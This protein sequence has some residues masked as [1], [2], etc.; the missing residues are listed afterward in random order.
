LRVPAFDGSQIGPPIG[1]YTYTVADDHWAWSDG[2]YELHGYESQG[3]VVT[4]ELM[5]QHKH[6]DDRARALGVLETAVSEGGPFSCYHRIIDQ[7]GR[8][9]SVLAVGRGV[10]PVHGRVEQLTGFFIDLT[11]LRRSETEA[12]VQQAL[13]GI[14]EHRAVIEQAKGV[15]MCA[16]G[17]DADEAFGILRQHSQDAN[18]KL[19]DLAHRLV[20]SVGGGATPSQAC[21]GVL[22]GFL[23]GL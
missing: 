13:L 8:I 1:Y 6:P 20:K 22:S 5:L 4:T 2:M 15:V 12:D 23:A 11:E 10:G 9:H 18:L 3:V 16:L 19:N 7:Q 17:C 21:R 14:A